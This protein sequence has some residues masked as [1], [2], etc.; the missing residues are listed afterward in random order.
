L[1]AEADINRPANRIDSLE[2]IRGRHALLHPRSLQF[3]ASPFFDRARLAF[4]NTT[5]LS[6]EANRSAKQQRRQIDR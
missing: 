1:R 3:R 4:R 5:F 2:M 6:L